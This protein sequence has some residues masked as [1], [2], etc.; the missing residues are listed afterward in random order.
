VEKM[1]LKTNLKA[2]NKDLK[3]DI[4]KQCNDLSQILKENKQQEKFE[5]YEFVRQQGLYNMIT[6]PRARKLTGLSEKEYQYIQIHYTELM[7]KYP[8]TKERAKQN[9][10]YSKSANIAKIIAI[11]GCSNCIEIVSEKLDVTENDLCE[12]CRKILGIYNSP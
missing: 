8:D 10:A 1:C 7:K 5:R 4:L 6:D 3:Q 12:D 9:L 11:K 2:Q